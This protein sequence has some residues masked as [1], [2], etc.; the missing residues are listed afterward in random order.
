MYPTIPDT[1]DVALNVDE[2]LD[3]SE[4]A[5]WIERMELVSADEYPNME[6]IYGAY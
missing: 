5:H 1:Q 2:N 4:F 6:I 3:K